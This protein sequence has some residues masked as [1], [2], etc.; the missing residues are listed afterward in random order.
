MNNRYGLD[1]AYFSRKLKLILGDID[2]YTPEELARELS[3]L[4]ITANYGEAVNELQ[5]GKYE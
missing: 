2:N 1:E 3:R 4:A 5:R